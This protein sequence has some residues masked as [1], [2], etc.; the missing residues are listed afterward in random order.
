MQGDNMRTRLIILLI[1]I[2]LPSIV[3]S[4]SSFEGRWRIYDLD[5][6]PRS[7]LEISSYKGKL[8]GTLAEII[9]NEKSKS[10]VCTACQ[11]KMHNQSL[12]GMPIIWG[13][14]QTADSWENGTILDT[15]SGNIYQCSLSVSKDNKTLNLH[16][17]KGMKLFGVTLHWKRIV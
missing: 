7:I 1:S 3:F 13:G 11:G 17:Y 4:K 6:T 9:P 10:L 16:A 12:K 14:I 15:D 8:I 2:L 5:H